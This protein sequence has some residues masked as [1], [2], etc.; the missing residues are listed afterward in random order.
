MELQEKAEKEQQAE[1][2]E[3][4]PKASSGMSPNEVDVEDATTKPTTEKDP[5]AAAKSDMQRLQI[6]AGEEAHME[7]AGMSA[8]EKDLRK[9]EKRKGGLTKEQRAELQGESSSYNF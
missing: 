2:E 1:V 5:V 3:A 6:T 4:T 7:A 8:A 9:T